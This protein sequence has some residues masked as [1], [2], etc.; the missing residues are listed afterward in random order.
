M[1]VQLLSAPMAVLADAL[2]FLGS[3]FFLVRT[4]TTEPPASTDKGA[5]TAGARF[6]ISSPI[7]RSSLLAVGTIN[8]FNLMFLASTCST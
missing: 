5:V 2:S 8:F 6:I 4:R 3:A 7:V 1:L